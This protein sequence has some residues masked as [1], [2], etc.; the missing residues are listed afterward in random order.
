MCG[1]AGFIGDFNSNGLTDSLGHRGPDFQDSYTSML[2][3]TKVHLT[4]TRLSIL[5]LSEAGHQP[6]GDPSGK[7][8]IVYNGEVYNFKELRASELPETHFKSSTDTE[9]ILHLF[10]K[11]GLE[12]V[13]LLNGAFAISIL[14]ERTET[15]H[16]I[17]DRA[18][19][20]PL[21]WHHQG[22]NLVFGSEIKAILK[23]GVNAE[24]DTDKLQRYFVFKYSP[25]NE[26]LFKGI[27]KVPTGTIISKQVGTNEHTVQ[28]YWNPNYISEDNY[29][30]SEKR[31]QLR[32][33]LGKA[34]ERRLIADVPIANFLSGGLDSSI[35]AHHLKGH[36]EIIHYCA[37]KSEADIAKEGT[38]SDYQ[39][40][41]QLADSW[42]LNFEEIRIGN[43]ELTTG[44]I[45]TTIK[46][47]DDLIADGSQIP[48]YLIARSASSKAKVVLSGMGADE[49]FLG[50]AGH[51]L[52]VMNLYLNNLPFGQKLLEKRFAR[53][54]AG[55]GKFKAFKRYLYK[56]GRYRNEGNYKCGLYSIVGDFYNSKSIFTPENKSAEEFLS[57]YFDT[58]EEPFEQMHRFEFENFLVKNLSYTDRMSMANGLENRVPFLDHNVIEL[59]YS[60][61]RKHKVDGWLKSKKVLKDAYSDV[62]PKYVT[63]RRKAGF[64]MPLR[65]LLG[66][67]EK[68]NELMDYHFFGNFNGF[69]MN[70]INEVIDNH[71]AGKQDN[72]SII[73]ALICFEHWYKEHIG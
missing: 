53:I 54:E 29:S 33:E 58:Q 23:A 9:T 45:R 46:Y 59:A 64:G 40:A 28:H 11:H 55:K 6:M 70:T 12:F 5:D 10:L 26:T 65:S 14:D 37:R 35:I 30:L 69:N 73:Y 36:N 72:S 47:A 52:A 4:H 32:D 42:G 41:K 19:I 24:L 3:G 43:E 62:I 56:L 25:G 38:T 68:I 27:E 8:H 1:I 20:K 48:A 22:T 63:Q 34:V 7:V 60:I 51:Q 2:S 71:V 49:L 31:H 13:H 67:K 44:Q 18:G 50:Y 66:N 17:R 61:K 57:L 16:L 39:Y 15:L 21:Y